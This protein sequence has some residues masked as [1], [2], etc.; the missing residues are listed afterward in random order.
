MTDD[1]FVLVLHRLVLVEPEDAQAQDDPEFKAERLKPPVLLMHGLMQD[2]ES[3][4]CAGEQSLGYMLA[5]AG[6][7]VWLGK[8]SNCAVVFHFMCS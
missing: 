3:F 4:L 8:K 6:F 1:G 5:K 7:D 2:S